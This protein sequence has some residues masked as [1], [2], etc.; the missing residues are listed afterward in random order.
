MRRAVQLLGRL[1]AEEEDAVA[2]AHAV[3]LGAR[4]R[5]RLHAQPAAAASIGQL[6]PQAI[7]LEVGEDGQPRDDGKY[8][9]RSIKRV[10]QVAPF[11]TEEVK[12]KLEELKEER[13]RKRQRQQ[14]AEWAVPS[15]RN[16]GD[17]LSA[18]AC[19]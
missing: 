8:Y 3:A 16:R 12:R 19:K 9:M 4:R 10:Y 17:V 6:H 18:R 14:Y 2:R 15:T 1:G 13:L 5:A 7:R 11:P